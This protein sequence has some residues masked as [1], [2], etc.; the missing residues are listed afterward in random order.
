VKEPIPFS[1]RNT[2]SAKDM[3]AKINGYPRGTVSHIYV[4]SDGGADLNLV[5]AMVER[6]DPHVK[7]VNQNTLVNMAVQRDLYL[8]QKTLTDLE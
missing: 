5:Y 8:K 6:L 7:I 2:L 3:A 1:Q 4:T